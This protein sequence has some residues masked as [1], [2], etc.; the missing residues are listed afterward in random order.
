MAA[1]EDLIK[2]IAEP[3]L[4]EQLATEVARLKAT[5]KF[6]LVFEEHLPELL[7]LPG[8]PVRAGTRVLKKDERGSMAY[9]VAS[10]LNG[11]EVKIV[12]EAGGP[13]EIVA[14]ESVVVAKAFGEP[15]Y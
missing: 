2:Q 11:Q 13:E 5:K 8:L 14:R 6:G 9:R 4:R 3:G 7:R 15:M 12:P 10:T 1:I